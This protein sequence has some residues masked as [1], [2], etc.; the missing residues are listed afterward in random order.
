MKDCLLDVIQYTHGLGCGVDLIKV[1]GTDKTTQVAAIG[2]GNSVIINGKFTNVVPEFAGTFGMPNLD[3]LKVVVGF[4][5]YDDKAKINMVYET[6]DGTKTPASI[7]FETGTG[8]FLNDY[9]L[10]GKTLVESQ[11]ANLALK[12]APK[13]EIEF[14]PTLASI[15]RLKKQA[16]ANSEELQFTTTI[17]SKGD[18]RASFGDPAAHSGNFVFQPKV[19][20]KLTSPFRWP[21]KAFLAILDLPGDKKIRISNQ[22]LAE[23]TVESGQASYSYM[24]PAHSK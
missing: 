22:G 15:T 7:H 11:I 23:I 6:K 20:G 14:E 17:D 19:S 3:K 13:W 8:D 12:V 5:D 24:F 1:I 9:R 21:V 2:E 16:S 4:D 10:M 18:L